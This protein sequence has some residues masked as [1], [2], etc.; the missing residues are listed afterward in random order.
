M[1]LKIC[2][3]LKVYLPLILEQRMQRFYIVEYYLVMDIHIFKV[4]LL[5]RGLGTMKNN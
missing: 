4:N 5:S 1:D 3:S 2:Y